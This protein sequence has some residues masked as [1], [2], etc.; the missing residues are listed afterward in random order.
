MV[1]DYSWVVRTGRCS[2][3][4]RMTL[5]PA[6]LGRAGFTRAG[7][8]APDLVAAGCGDR[9]P[10]PEVTYGDY[11]GSPWCYIAAAAAEEQKK[12]KMEIAPCVAGDAGP[13]S[14]WV[15]GPP[16]GD[17]QPFLP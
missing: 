8:A 14:R 12:K 5:C 11:P 2:P 15:P 10:G 17:A 7:R 13:V 6:A 3:S 16:N 1:S 9:S 4:R